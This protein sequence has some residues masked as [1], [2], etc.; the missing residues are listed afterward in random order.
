MATI[1]ME[2][3]WDLYPNSLGPKLKL[4]IYYPPDP[5]RNLH[6]ILAFL[7]EMTIRTLPRDPPGEGGQE[8]K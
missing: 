4:K 2:V 1:E 3:C 6:K 7:K 5:G 8:Q